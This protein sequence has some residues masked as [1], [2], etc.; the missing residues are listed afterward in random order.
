MR[1]E[2]VAFTAG[3]RAEASVRLLSSLVTRSISALAGVMHGRGGGA[4]DCGCGSNRYRQ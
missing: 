2:A 1:Q 3:E 4:E